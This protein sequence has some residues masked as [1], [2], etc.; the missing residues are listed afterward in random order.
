MH[1]HG[2]QTEA[3]IVVRIELFP[4]FVPF[5]EEIK[6]VMSSGAG[7]LGMAIPSE[8]PWT[9]GDFVIGKVTT[10]DGNSGIGE[11][12]VW[13]PETGISTYAVIESVSRYLGKYILG[14]SPFY[15]ERIRQRMD[16]NVARN[17]VPK[18]LLDMACYDL[19]GKITG[20]SVYDLIGGCVKERMPMSA[21]IPLTDPGTMVDIAGMFYAQGYRS[22]RVK[23][24]GGISHDRDIIESIRNKLGAGAKIRVDYNQAYLPDDAI[25][26]IRAIEPFVIDCAEQPVSAM[27][28]TGMVH[29]QKNVTTPLMAHEGCFSIND[30]ISLAEIGAVNILGINSERP[31]G[32]SCALQIIS[33]AEKCGM[34]VVI[35]NQPLGISSAM[36]LHLACARYNSLGHAPEVFGHIMFEDDLIL[37]ELD[38]S[39]G[40]AVVPAG[41][42]WGVTLDDDALSRYQTGESVII[43]I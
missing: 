6:S 24:G 34:G 10:E 3:P 35:H 7:G 11:V 9:G 5:R 21:L 26:A 30:C 38:Y 33:Y 42:G 4:L 19:M 22:F 17:E 29:V 20:H 13:M 40:C 2:K 16:A 28:V 39:G 12:F 1:D 43:R 23:L 31:G 18:G 41:P 14:N 36:H 15:I 27:D 8:D 32:L 25:Q 37:E